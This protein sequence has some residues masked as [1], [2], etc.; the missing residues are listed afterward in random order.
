MLRIDIEEQCKAVR[1]RLEGKIS[2][3]WVVELDRCWQITLARPT[4]KML[5]VALETVT[6]VDEAGET[7]L[8]EM[9]KAGA[10]LVGKGPLSC[11]LV[12]QI[13]QRRAG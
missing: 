2:G 11:H 7:L 9:H 8:R 5:V 4:N 6:Y 10:R 3:A 1:I 12:E 13:Q